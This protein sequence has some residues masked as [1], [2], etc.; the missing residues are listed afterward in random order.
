MP[1]V[2]QPCRRQPG[3]ANDPLERLGER[4][5]VSGA[6]VLAGEQPFGNPAADPRCGCFLPVT[7]A[8]EHG[9]GGRVEFDLAARVLGLAP[10]DLSFV[11][12]GH[13]PRSTETL[14]LAQS[15]SL[16]LRPSTSLRR[17]PVA[18][19]NLKAAYSR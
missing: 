6:A 12:D 18:A 11:A 5:R 14:D 7:P 16:H 1:Q 15:M 4:V 3:S 8:A 13:E 10:R 2:V 9:E 17:I 19:L